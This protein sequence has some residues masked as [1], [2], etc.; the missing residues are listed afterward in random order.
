M[1]PRRYLQTIDLHHLDHLH[2]LAEEI[3]PHV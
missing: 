2:P 3:Q 1:G